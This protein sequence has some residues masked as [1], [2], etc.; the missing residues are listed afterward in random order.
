M[1][2]GKTYVLSRVETKRTS[3]STEDTLTGT[4]ERIVAIVNVT[5][6]EKNTGVTLRTLSGKGSGGAVIDKK[7]IPRSRVKV[8]TMAIKCSSRRA[9][10]IS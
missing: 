4:R 5:T 9:L 6:F 3:L 10:S 8:C 2:A 1:T 7:G